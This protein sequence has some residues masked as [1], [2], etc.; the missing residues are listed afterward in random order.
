MIKRSLIT[1]F[2]L[3]LYILILPLLPSKYSF[4]GIPINGDIIFLFILVTYFISIIFIKECRKRFK[5]GVVD[6]FSN[7]LSIF[8][9]IFMI[10]MCISIFYSVDKKIA[11]SEAIRFSSYFVIFFIIKYELNSRKITNNI[12]AVYLFVTSII[13]LIGLLEYIL[14]IGFVQFGRDRI[15]STLENSNN[16]GMYMVIAIFPITM[17]MLNEKNKKKKIMF[18]GLFIIVLSNIIF[19]YSRNAW[20]GLVI[21]CI[22]LSLIYSRKIMIYL[23]GAGCIGFFIPQIHSRI[24][25]ILDKS[26][27]L[28]RIK[29]WDIALFMIKDHPI[30]G[31]GMGNYRVLYD[32]YKLK[33]TKKIEYYPSDKFHPH[34]I[35]LKIQSEIGIIGSIAFIGIIVSVILRLRK[36][37]SSTTNNFYKVFYKGFFASLISFIFMNLIDNFFSAPKVIAFFWILIAVFEASMYRES[38]DLNKG[39]TY[40]NR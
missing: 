16:L 29:L 21:G 10:I 1:S 24:L 5:N 39:T 15:F 12:I 26:Q 23:M 11:V 4:K 8:M 40:Y 31:V 17:I 25:E 28:S 14:G 32:K 37:I 7:Y 19:S 34:N 27:N 18:I 30:K 9:I 2:F 33:M 13:A 20:L 38:G 3:Y 22:V 35:L 6:F 36:Y